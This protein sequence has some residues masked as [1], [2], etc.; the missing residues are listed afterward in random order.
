ME[1]PKCRKTVSE[2]DYECPY[3]GV[4][5]KQRPEKKPKRVRAKAADSGERVKRGLFMRKKPPMPPPPDA[6][7][8]KGGSGLKIAA[9]IICGVL[10]VIIIVAVAVSLAGSKGEKYA[11]SAAEYIGSGLSTIESKTDMHFLDESKY[12]GVNS[13]VAFDYVLESDKSTSV[14]GVEYPEW[15]VFLK[16]SSADFVTDVTYTDFSVVHKDIRGVKHKE[17][18]DLDSFDE[19]AKQAK[20]MNYIDIDPYSICYSQSGR[21]TYTYKYYYKLDNGDEQAAVLRVV[22]NEDGKFKYSTTELVY[23]DNM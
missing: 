11:E 5:I 2:Y 15:A 1:C 3:C 23:P 21:V 18:I 22:F 10:I 17:L 12:S 16:M 19:N 8:K 9:L 7:R 13:A 6:E 20:V 4:K 14:W